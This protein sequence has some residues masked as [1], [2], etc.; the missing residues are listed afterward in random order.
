LPFV[1]GEGEKS[2]RRRPVA[3]LTI[4]LVAISLATLTQL[5]L[6]T[7]WSPAM[8]AWSRIPIPNDLLHN[9]T[10]LERQ[11]A[12]VFQVKQCHNCHSLGDGGGKRGPAL[13]A[14]A[15]RLTQDQLIRQVIQGGGN[16]PSY[17]KNL[18]PAETTAL[19]AFLETLHPAGQR[20]AQ[21]ASRSVV[22]DENATPGA[23]DPR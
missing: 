7:P 5:G 22:L 18:S 15:L 14:V 4:L 11:G 23:S 8:D 2:W 3:V 21:D 12:L 9:R 19:V 10:A 20:P 13:D 1:F 16:M 17:G 6:H